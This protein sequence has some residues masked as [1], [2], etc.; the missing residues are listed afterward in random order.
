VVLTKEQIL[1]ADDIKTETVLVP[2]WGG[3]VIVRGLSGV[4]RDAYEMAVYRPDGKLTNNPRNIRSQLVARSCVD[5][6]GKRL[7]TSLDAEQLGKKSGAALDRVFEVAAK[8][9]G[10][11]K[12]DI[13]E[14][15]KNSQDD[16][17][18]GSG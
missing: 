10:I 16:Q 17:S 8:L 14:I 1:S 2:E 18:E 11:R 7:F 3:D 5:E 6:N 9:S 4:E 15:A 13:E 12:E